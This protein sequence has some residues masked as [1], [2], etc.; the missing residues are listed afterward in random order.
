MVHVPFSKWTLL[1]VHSAV[2]LFAR[3]RREYY[4]EHASSTLASSEECLEAL[5]WHSTAGMLLEL[6]AVLTAFG[7]MKELDGM[8]AKQDHQAQ[9]TILG[10]RHA[11]LPVREKKSDE[12]KG[13]KKK[14]WRKA[15]NE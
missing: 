15:T 9:S 14:E 11:T 10:R 13:A 2:P 8:T 7:R 6:A 1:F 12:R 5:E 4:A 3:D